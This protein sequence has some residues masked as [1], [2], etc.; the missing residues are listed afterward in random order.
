M[1]RSQKPMPGPCGYPQPVRELAWEEVGAQLPLRQAPQQPQP[2]PVWFWQVFR[3]KKAEGGWPTKPPWGWSPF[4]QRL[5]QAQLPLWAHLAQSLPA[6]AQTAQ[7]VDFVQY[8]QVQVQVQVQ[9]S[10]PVLERAQAMRRVWRAGRPPTPSSPANRPLAAA[11]QRHPLPAAI[12]AGGLCGERPRAG[13]SADFGPLHGPWQRS[14]PPLRPFH[15]A[16][17]HH[18]PHPMTT[19]VAWRAGPACAAWHRASH[20]RLPPGGL[21]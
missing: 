3:A 14:L 1:Q 18:C 9:M 15:Q 17:A 20:S 8:F 6:F 19:R 5:V 21:Q 16:A 2:A 7:Q 11:R 13:Q 12:C 4:F 10:A